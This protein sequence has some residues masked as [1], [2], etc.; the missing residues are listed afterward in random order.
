MQRIS[1]KRYTSYK[2]FC[3]FASVTHHTQHVAGLAKMKNIF[4]YNSR[5]PFSQN[6]FQ[7]ELVFLFNFSKINQFW[8]GLLHLVKTIIRIN[9]IFGYFV[10]LLLKNILYYHNKILYMYICCIQVVSCKKNLQVGEYN[11]W[12]RLWVTYWAGISYVIECKNGNCI[13]KTW[14]CKCIINRNWSNYRYL[15]HDSTT[16]CRKLV[17][18][19]RFFL[20]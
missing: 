17:F 5:M 14:R 6:R 9:M 15:L 20:L 8:K 3:R 18:Y 2:L 1:W 12:E 4:P 10:K 13:R 19:T 11:R 16:A 7:C